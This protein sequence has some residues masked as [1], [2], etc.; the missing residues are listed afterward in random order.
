VLA[1]SHI[2]VTDPAVPEYAQEDLTMSAAV[3]SWDFSYDLGNTTL[4]PE[5]QVPENNGIWF[6]R[7]KVYE[8]SVYEW[9]NIHRK[10]G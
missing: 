3:E 10:N 5:V 4:Q 2:V 1:T 8:D 6:T 7:R 9:M